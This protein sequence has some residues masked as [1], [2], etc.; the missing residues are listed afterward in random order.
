MP[1]PTSTFGLIERARAGDRDAFES[2]FSKY[3]RRL[4]VLIHY[5]LSPELRRFADEDDILQETLLRAFSALSE[6]DYRGPGSFLGWS[7]RIAGNVLADLDRAHRRARRNDAAD[8][9]LEDVSPADSRTP[10]RVL[11]QKQA[12]HAVLRRLDDLPPDYRS[13]ILMAKFESL[14]TAEMAER[15]GRSREAVAVLLH[16]ALARYGEL[17]KRKLP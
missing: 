1:A 17:L 15:L 5:K 10:S 13:V 12:V 16:R 7:A 3:R 4:A 2:L 6:F 8:A 11:A 14:T 9:P